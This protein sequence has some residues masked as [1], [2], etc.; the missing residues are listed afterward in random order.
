MRV[1]EIFL[2]IQGEGLTAGFPT[3]FVRFSG[4]NL[5]CSYCD[6][7][8]AY[9]TGED[10]SYT[11]IV[12][13][14]ARLYYKRVCLTGGE[15]LMQKDLEKLIDLLGD[16]MV[17]IETNGSINLRDKELTNPLHSYVMDMKTPSSGCSQRMIFDNFAF[18]RKRDEIKFVIGD[19]NDY[20]W[21]KDVISKF[22]KKGTITLS[23]VYGKIDYSK[24]VEWILADKLDL[25][26]QTQLHKVIWGPDKTGV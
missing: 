5:R 17:T 22:Y 18:L 12:A 26:F 21:A 2:S 4:C 20:L 14:I 10:M 6:T 15:P 7:K 16:Y 11:D 8:Y 25:R 3:V 23:P 9:D 13:K 24:I 19:R 1:N